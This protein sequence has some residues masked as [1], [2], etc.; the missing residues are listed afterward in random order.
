M[1]EIRSVMNTTSIHFQQNEIYHCDSFVTL[2]VFKTALNA[3]P[4]VDGNIKNP[5]FTTEQV[6]LSTH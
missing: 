6:N 4:E 2:L 5:Q 3:T 1:P